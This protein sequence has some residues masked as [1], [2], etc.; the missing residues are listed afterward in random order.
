M[1]S[2]YPPGAPSLSGDV[3]SINR[4]LKDMPWVLRALRTISDQMFIS[5]RIL[6]GQLFTPNGSIGYEQTESIYAD[7]VP[8][9]VGPSGEYPV[10]SI[11]TGPASTANTVN[12]GQDAEITDADIRRLRYD[13]VN[14]NFRKL[15]NSH[16]LQVDSVALAA[17]A[18]AVTQNTDAL[19][20]WAATDG[21]A[22]ILRDVMR[23]VAKILG[24]KQGYM[25]DTVLCGLDTFANV[26]S[27]DK[28]VAALAREYP[29][30]DNA[31]VQQGMNSNFVKQIG[32]L[33]WVTSPNLPVTGKATVLDSTLLGS[34]VDE[35]APDPGYVRGDNMIQVKTI[36]D[37]EHDL[38][39][40]RCRRIV[41]PIVQ[42]PA[43]AWVI[44][45]V[46][47]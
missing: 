12:W 3:L 47:A 41:V 37:D 19:A 36:R 1:G 34:F 13:A 28:L 7:R 17:V 11:S 42:E 45:G 31:P 21:S 4:F 23:A 32:G 29:G 15:M 2:T 46:D 10:T 9:P 40:L 33:T 27:D 5:N 35:E 14:R 22:K 16:V 25:P 38:W 44:N 24:L 6:R 8:K 26:T 43:A 30:V 39:R 20:S 18:S